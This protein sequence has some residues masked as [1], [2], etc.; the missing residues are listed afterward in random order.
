MYIDVNET[1]AKRFKSR[2]KNV[3]TEVAVILLG[4]KNSAYYQS[5]EYWVA[6]SSLLKDK[7]NDFD[8]Y[9]EEGFNFNDIEKNIKLVPNTNIVSKSINCITVKIKD[10]V[11]QFCRYHAPTLI[12]LIYSFDFAHCQIGIGIKS[13][14]NREGN[15]AFLLKD[16]LEYTPNW[17]KAM[18]TQSTFYIGSDYPLSSLLRINKYKE[19]GL[20]N[21]TSYK[22]DVLKVCAD[23]INRGFASYDDFK[24]QL[25]AI[26]LLLFSEAEEDAA[27]KLF[28][29]CCDRGLVSN[30]IVNK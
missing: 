2:F 14:Y 28:N 9:C 18:L 20:Y 5:C 13:F 6:G 22:V 26:D 19:R 21:A 3:A 1:I 12:E 16:K 10:T 27:Y 4:S 29:T 11:V 24:D 15:A 30:T 7:P 23:I 25:A 17:E 8:L